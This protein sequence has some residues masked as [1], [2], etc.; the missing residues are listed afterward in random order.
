MLLQ[1]YEKIYKNLYELKN[2]HQLSDYELVELKELIMKIINWIA[3]DEENIKKGVERM[4]GKVLEFEHDILIR[5]SE[6]KQKV[7]S[8]DNLVKNAH[9]DVDCA[10]KLLGIQLTDYYEAKNFLKNQSKISR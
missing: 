8:V 6:S 5:E 9:V 4:G 1:E 3:A 2:E 7:S 10:C